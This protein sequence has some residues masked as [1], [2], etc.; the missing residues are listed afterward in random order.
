MRIRVLLE[1]GNI[2]Q[3]I[4]IVFEGRT[5]PADIQRKNDYIR[6][7]ELLRKTTTWWR[8]PEDFTDVE[9]DQAQEDFDIFGA[10]YL[11]MFGASAITNYLQI[12]I[13]GTL[14]DFLKIYRN[15]YQYA[16]ISFEG[17]VGTLRGFILKRTQGNGS[18]GGGKKGQNGNVLCSNVASQ[19]RAKAYRDIAH[20]LDTIG[21][22]GSHIIDDAVTKGKQLKRAKL[23]L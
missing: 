14:K 6:L 9:I 12:V 19:V 10:H 1:K 7:F 13:G 21:G 2:R 4:E 17:Y 5:S 8:K 22:V 20:T 3:F 15:L 11:Q 18:K 23:Q 16:N